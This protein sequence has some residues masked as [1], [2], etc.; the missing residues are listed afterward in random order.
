MSIARGIP[1]QFLYKYYDF[2]RESWGGTYTPA[3]GSKSAWQSLATSSVI[4]TDIYSM[5]LRIHSH[6]TSGA[7]RPLVIDVGIDLAGGTS[8][9]VLIPDLIVG[10]AGNFYSRGGHRFSF[11]IHIP[12]GA[13]LGIRG[14]SNVTSSYRGALALYGK[15]TRP[16]MVSVGTYFEALGYTSAGLGTAL[17]PGVSGT[18]GDYVSLGTTTKDLWNF[19]VAYYVNNAVRSITAVT[20]E[21]SYGVGKVPIIERYMLGA[22]N[23]EDG[24]IYYR[25]IWGPELVNFVPAGSELFIRGYSSYSTFNTGNTAMMIAVGG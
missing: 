17:T 2:M 10:N 3:S 16:E 20:Y 24:G 11:P 13:S 6:F 19:Q 18:W 12:A 9:T 14:Q 5:L 7:T 1:N 22:T 8:Y 15:P 4:N 25:G 21:L 23:E